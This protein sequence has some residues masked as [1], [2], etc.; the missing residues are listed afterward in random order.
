LE[1]VGWQ[2]GQTATKDLDSSVGIVF[3]F[4]PEVGH[5]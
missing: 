1:E 2:E 4:A 5:A 3:L